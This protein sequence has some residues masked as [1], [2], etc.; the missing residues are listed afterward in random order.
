MLPPTFRR[1]GKGRRS[2]P[3]LAVALV[4]GVLVLLALALASGA[5]DTPSRFQQFVGRLHPLAVHLPIGFL[6]LAVALEGA[7]LWPPLRR[8]RH[9]I[10][11]VL[12]L[13]AA[14]AV[15]AVLA[16]YLL[17]ATGGYD[18]PTVLWHKRMGIAVAVASVIAVGLWHANR[19]RPSTLLRT[20]YTGSLLASA[21]FLMIAG[22]LGGSL[23]HGPEFLT[24]Y[25]PAPL[26]AAFRLLPGEAQAAPTLARIDEAEIY[27]HL[28]QPVLQARCVACHGPN[29]QKGGLRLDSVGT[30]LE[31]GEDGPALVPGRSAESE[32][33]RRIWL[34][35]GHDEVMPPRGKKPLTALEAELIRWWIDE[36]ASTT[37]TVGEAKPTP[38]VQVL[39]EQLAGPP[40]QRV[41]PVLRTNIAAADSTALAKARAGGLSLRPIA[42]GSNFLRA[43]CA[44]TEK[45]CG[46]AH[47]QLLLPLAPQLATLNLSDAAIGD[48]ELAEVARFP[49]LIRLHLERTRVTDAGMAH[50]GTMRNLEYLNLHGTTVGDSGLVQ[51][52]GLQHLRS[53]FLWQTAATPAGVGRLRAQLP[54]LRADLG[55]SPAK[56]DSIRAEARADSIRT[57]AQKAAKK[58]S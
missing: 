27:R 1:D 20:A 35:A 14:S 18:G 15:M 47:I 57:A 26:Q 39:L 53:L 49:N 30:M 5:D 29:A 56:A 52:A 50:V 36:G 4:L 31:G 24:E 11:F 41:A 44:A 12:V 43:R 28:A 6:L 2:L 10:P 23:T 21:G 8:L 54:K 33:V 13:G 42:A 55:I 37:K 45:E 16:G 25:M 40:A 9:A 19:L 3:A 22:H 17:A 38:S 7:A 58:R 48:A 51:L 32:M 34:P 46:I